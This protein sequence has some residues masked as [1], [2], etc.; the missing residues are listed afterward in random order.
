MASSFDVVC[1]PLNE[2]LKKTFN[3]RK[4]TSQENNKSVISPSQLAECEQCFSSFN[5]T[6]NIWK[7]HFGGVSELQSSKETKT[8]EL[9]R[10]VLERLKRKIYWYVVIMNKLS[11]E[12]NCMCK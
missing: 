6:R 8:D 11:K 1:I 12:F 7:V 10:L 2:T 3:P 4:A 9:E 5:F